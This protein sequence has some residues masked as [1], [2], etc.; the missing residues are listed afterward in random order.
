MFNVLTWRINID[1][2][3][4]RSEIYKKPDYSISGCVLMF[5]IDAE[6][7]SVRFRIDQFALTGGTIQRF[8]TTAET[9]RGIKL[10]VIFLAL[11]LVTKHFD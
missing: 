11:L 4:V 8:K 1:N 10:S 3:A 5:L 2:D 9:D 7:Q 6:L